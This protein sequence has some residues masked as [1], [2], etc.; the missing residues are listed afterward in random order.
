MLV[1]A[2]VER[3]LEV[4]E[5]D[6]GVN[7]DAVDAVIERTAKVCTK[8]TL[9]VDNLIVRSFFSCFCCNTMILDALILFYD[10]YNAVCV[11]DSRML[12][13]KWR[14]TLMKKQT[15]GKEGM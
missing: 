4:S 13:Q 12:E 1:K 7:A 2:T 10:D 5:D 3:R 9:E 6:D 14:E 11:G 15:D 8:G